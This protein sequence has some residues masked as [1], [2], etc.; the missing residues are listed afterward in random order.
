MKVRGAKLGLGRQREKPL[1]VYH[2]TLLDLKFM[3]KYELHQH[4]AETKTHN[5]TGNTGYMKNF[6]TGSRLSFDYD[7]T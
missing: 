2:L 3:M 1:K 4:S 7:R 5:E 6:I